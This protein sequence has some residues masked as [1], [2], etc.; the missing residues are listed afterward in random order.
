MNPICMKCGTEMKCK[1]NDVLI[2]SEND[3]GPRYSTDLYECMEKGCDTLI[4]KGHSEML[5]GDYRKDEV[6]VIQFRH[7]PKNLK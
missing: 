3:K 1:Q 4:A 5:F 7:N 2:Q 6:P